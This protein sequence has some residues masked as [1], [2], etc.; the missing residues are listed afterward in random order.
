V[1]ERT[2]DAFV[3]AAGDTAKAFASTLES[4]LGNV[5][6]LFGTSQ[7][8]DQDMRLAQ[9]GAY[10]PKAD[11]YLRQLSDEVINGKEWGDNVDIKDA[12][13]RAGID[14]N[15]PN[16]IVLELVKEAWANQS[17]FANPANLD[18][19]NTDAV[20][21]S[22]EEQQKESQGKANIMAMFGLTDESSQ[23]TA[24]QL[25]AAL[26]SVFGQAAESDAMAAS[27]AVVFNKLLTGFTDPATAA[28]GVGAMGTAITA[29]TG[30][31]ENVAILEDAGKTAYRHFFAGWAVAAG[32]APVSPPAGYGPPTNPTSPGRAVGTGFWYG[33]AMT[34]HA[35]ETIY[36]PR[37]TRVDRSGSKA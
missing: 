29:A 30:A 4:A 37:G 18:L 34:V 11:E 3:A 16:E 20:K 12:A 23:A 31:P 1:Q 22:L 13:R 9:F 2:G 28:S 8:T 10:K 21:A 24:D 33:G 35:D 14:P 15:L 7:V 17:F 32:E 36:A 6:G 5:P 27:G 19:I 26:N 25:G